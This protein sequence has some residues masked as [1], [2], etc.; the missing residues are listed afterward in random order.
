MNYPDPLWVFGYGSLTWKVGFEYEEKVEG[1][2]TGY[3]RRFYQS[4]TDHRGVPGKPGRVVTLVEEPEGRTW[5]IAYRIPQHLIPTIMP[6]LDHR[7]KGGYTALMKE[8]HLKLGVSHSP[9]EAL[10]YIGT[11]DNEDWA[12]PGPLDEVAKQMAEAVG[13]SGPNPEYLFNLAE[14]MRHICP[15]EPDP[16]LYELEAKVKALV[17]KETDVHPSE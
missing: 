12:G 17:Q 11:E 4:S 15:E 7:E 3:V 2:I 16:H 9:V 14:A 10:V 6:Q 13:P 5:G 8:V 1:Y